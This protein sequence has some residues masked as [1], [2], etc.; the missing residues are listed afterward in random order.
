MLRMHIQ[1]GTLETSHRAGRK[2]DITRGHPREHGRWEGD[3][4]DGGPPCSTCGKGS[5]ES[6]SARFQKL[7]SHVSC[8]VFA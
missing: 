3:I 2:K 4:N 8:S 1:A 7:I 5:S 6:R